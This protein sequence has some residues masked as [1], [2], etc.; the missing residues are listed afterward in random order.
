MEN[1]EIEKRPNQ[2]GKKVLGSAILLVGLVL[3]A[4]QMG[5][6]LPSWLFSWPMLLIFI[7][8]VSGI[9]HQFKTGGWIMM[10]LIGAVFLAERIF[11]ELSVTQYTWPVILIGLGVFF[12]FGK[13]FKKHDCKRRRR[14][15]QRYGNLPTDNFAYAETPKNEE[16]ATEK[17]KYHVA[18]EEYIDSVSVFGDTKKSILS[19]NFKGGDVTNIMGGAELNFYHADINGVVVLEVVQIFGG[20]KIIVPPSWE[21]VTEMAA[22]F[23][24]IDDKRSL[25]Q[26]LPDK[27]KVLVIKGTSIFGGIDIRNF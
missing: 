25:T 15:E 24:G 6:A 3:L 10:I 21:V 16:P 22:V 17:K 19:K 9:K 5:V 20:T 13:G 1:P 7:G 12:I 26:V 2:H 18:G 4:K 11:P 23:G 14:W 27:S 8:V